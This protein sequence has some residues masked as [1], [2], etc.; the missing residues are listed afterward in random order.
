MTDPGA[1]EARRGA[2]F[3]ARAVLAALALGLVAVPFSLLLLW[4]E[5]QWAPLLHADQAA[6]DG[7]HAFALAHAGFVTA[8]DV[9]STI[10]RWWA[11]LIGFA[12]VLG[13]LLW[14]RLVRLALFVV[15][16]VGGSGLLNE[17]VKA[18]VH[19]ARPV[20]TDPV[21]HETGTSF[22]SGHA[23]GA[24]VGYGV[25]LLVVLPVLRGVARP[26][27][28]TAALLMVLAIGFSRVALG[29]HYVSD[30]LAGYV[31][32][33]A[34]TAAMLASFNTWRREDAPREDP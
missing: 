15:V 10:G 7:L 2:R 8:M 14:R 22:P 31:L 21:A 28:V 3:G 23:Q 19:R 6:R 27:A 25:L 12:I 29:V 17:I 9:L 16:T 18:A 11:Y 1:E 24:I 26:I 34:W 20:L 32:G 13:W 4:V 30:V 5:A 33:A